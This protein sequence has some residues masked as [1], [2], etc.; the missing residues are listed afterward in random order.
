MNRLIPLLG[1]ALL[2]ASP[3]M[4]QIEIQNVETP[5]GHSA[6]LV[7]ERSIP[8]IAIDVIFAGGASIEPLEQAGVV[9]LMTSLLNE[10]A[11]DLDAQGFAAALESTAGTIS[12]EAGRDSV[13]VS[14]RALSENRDAVID[15]AILALTQP[16]FTD[17]AV[18]RVRSQQVA[19]LER[20]LQSPAA[21]AAAAWREMGYPGHPYSTNSD[22]SPASIAALTRDDIVAAHGMALARNRA[23]VGAAGDIAANELAALIDRLLAGLPESTVP[24]PDY[25][26]YLGAPG[27]TVIPYD[28]P[29]SAVQFGF[30]GL[31]VD[32]PDYMAAM[33]VNEY[34]GGGRF[35]TVLMNALRE[36]RGLTYGVGMSLSSGQFG[37]AYVGGFATDNATAGQALQVLRE[38]FALLAEQGLTQAD[39]DRVVTYL[40]GAYP[41]RFDG[42]GDIAGIMAAMQFQ[43]FG[44]DYVNVR[45]DR[46]R[47]VTLEQVNA[48]AARL[49][50]PDDLTIVIAGR[51]EGLE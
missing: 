31:H 3:V 9:S 23:F 27:V 40:T 28:G 19:S 15:L 51:P 24:L 33:I 1:A 7:E 41:L 16:R 44:I 10:G 11:G 37:D 30:A 43:D 25:Q 46:M 39:M 5:A 35:G 21:Q 49:A 47:A 12:F 45:N 22:G 32:D 50:R 14:I 2:A 8:M 36:E 34:F 29:Q 20:E 13:T 26:P 6:W 38:Q 4:A 17:D 48:M 18:E 42:N